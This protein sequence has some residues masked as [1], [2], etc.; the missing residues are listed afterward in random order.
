[1]KK[2]IAVDMDN[3]LVDIEQHFIDWLDKYFERVDKVFEYK[4]KNKGVYYTK[5]QIFQTYE[6]AMLEH[7]FK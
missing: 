4:S 6:K 1:M 3:V 5:E 7:P 2:T